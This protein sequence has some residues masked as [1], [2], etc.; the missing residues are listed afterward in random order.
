[1]K[2]MNIQSAKSFTLPTYPYNY[3]VNIILY[4]G[5][6]IIVKLFFNKTKIRSSTSTL[7]F[8]TYSGL[9]IIYI[10]LVPIE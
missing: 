6:Y 8:S 7:F 4:I 10:F 9:L 2:L 5:T 3:N 1:M